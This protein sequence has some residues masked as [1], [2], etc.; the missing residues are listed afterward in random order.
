MD[1]SEGSD[2]K[3]KHSECDSGSAG[4]SAYRDQHFKV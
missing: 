1:L 2:R 4:L 3:R